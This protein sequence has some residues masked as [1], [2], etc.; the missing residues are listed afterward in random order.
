MKLL[1][2]GGGHGDLNMLISEQKDVKNTAKAFMAAQN[3]GECET[4]KIDLESSL[5]ACPWQSDW[6]NNTGQIN[7]GSIDL[8]CL[9]K[10]GG[11][12]I[13]NN[14]INKAH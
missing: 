14:G 11:R 4:T 6:I 12:S 3:S 8:S 1:S 5:R 10:I 13:R 7:R 2:L 9:Y